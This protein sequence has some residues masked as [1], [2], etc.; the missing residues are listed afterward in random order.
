ML[1]PH[2]K[3]MAIGTHQKNLGSHAFFQDTCNNYSISTEISLEF[4]FNVGVTMHFFKLVKFLEN[5]YGA[6]FI[7]SVNIPS[8]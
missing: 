7:F 6:C 1:G 5:F 2:G 3:R 8:K 4:A